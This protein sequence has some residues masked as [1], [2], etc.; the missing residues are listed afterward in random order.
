LGKNLGAQLLDS[1]A[2]LWL[3]LSVTA[4]LAPKVAV[5]FLHF[6]HSPALNES[7]TSTPAFAIISVLDFCHSSRVQNLVVRICNF[8]MT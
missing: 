4:K 6:P 3:A 5:P 8:L 7:S 1:M 2:R